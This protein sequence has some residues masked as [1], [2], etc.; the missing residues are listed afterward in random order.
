MK[1]T[2]I[3]IS[4][5]LLALNAAPALADSAHHNEGH[6]AMHAAQPGHQATGVVNRVDVPNRKINLTHGPIKSLGWM[7]MTMDFQV[8]DAALLNGIAPG[9]KVT[10]EVVNEG[11]GKYFV[12]RIAPQ[13]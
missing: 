8:R 9:Q 12:T 10:F 4:A 2:T 11:P 3:S 7:G 6:G 13:K 5:F 1:F